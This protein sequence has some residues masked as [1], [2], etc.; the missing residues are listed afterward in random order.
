[1]SLQNLFPTDSNTLNPD[2]SQGMKIKIEFNI[3][4]VSIY[5][6]MENT[7]R[8]GILGSAIEW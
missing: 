6:L 3:N 1:M 5:Y 7:T 2:V 8:T 4:T